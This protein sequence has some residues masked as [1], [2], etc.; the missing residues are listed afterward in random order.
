L[1]PK[2]CIGGL[3]IF[4]L[5]PSCLSEKLIKTE[6]SKQVLIK[7]DANGNKLWDKTYGGNNFDFL[8]DLIITSDGGYLIGGTSDSNIN[9]YKSQ[10]SKGGDDYW[11]IKVDS[12]GNKLWDKTIGGNGTD[13]LFCLFQTINGNYILGGG[14]SSNNSGDKSQLGQGGADFWILTLDSSGN[15]IWDKSIGGPNSEQVFS[16]RK[17]FDGGLI[18]GGWSGSGLGGDKTETSRGGT[19]FW[20]V[21]LAPDALGINEP[22]LSSNIT[23]SPNPNQGKFTLQLNNLK[24]PMAEVTVSDLLGRVVLQQDLKA[25]G[26]QISQEITLPET[27]GMYLLQV[28]AG[29][30]ISTRKIIVE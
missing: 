16:L 1:K 3:F 28:K 18:L 4:W 2:P 22:E 13:Q 21:K 11:I 26:N 30:Q 6:N 12:L 23:I 10:N 24:T 5:S 27:K 17:T 9:S 25:T 7:I 29:E 20:V 19:D 8:K 15:I 14:S